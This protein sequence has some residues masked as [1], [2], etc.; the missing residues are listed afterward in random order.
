MSVK[1]LRAELSELAAVYLSLSKPESMFKVGPCLSAQKGEAQH[2][3]F[4]CPLG[5]I[6]G[7]L[8]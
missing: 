7:T 8:K 2:R 4:R 5:K 6:D 3:A 1:T